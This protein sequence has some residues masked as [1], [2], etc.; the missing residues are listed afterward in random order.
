MLSLRC[1]LG[2]SNGRGEMSASGVVSSARAELGQPSRANLGVRSTRRRTKSLWLRPPYT[3]LRQARSGCCCCNFSRPAIFAP[4]F[5][6]S[7]VVDLLRCARLALGLLATVSARVEAGGQVHARARERREKSWQ[8]VLAR[9]RAIRTAYRSASN[10]KRSLCFASFQGR[11]AVNKENE[12]RPRTLPSD[13]LRFHLH[14]R[15]PA[16][17]RPTGRADGRCCC[18]RLCHSDTQTCVAQGSFWGSGTT[19]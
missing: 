3:G 2:T 16:S 17:R 14:R 7:F 10:T 9:C 5:C 12:E 6:A 19:G 8:V 11:R 15:T 13:V 18:R 1:A 4:T